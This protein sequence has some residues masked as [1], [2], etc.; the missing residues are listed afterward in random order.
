MMRGMLHH[1][2]LNVSNLEKST[3]FWGEL[4]E[5]LGYEPF[6][7][8]ESGRSFKLGDTYLVFVQ[9]EKKFL[10]SSYHRKEVGL[11]HLA[12]YADSREHVDEITNQLK[13]KDVSILYSDRHPHA[14]GPNHYAVFFEDP[15]RIKVEIVAP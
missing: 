6:Q 10:E 14:G 15:D 5:E 7:S 9:T 4:L 13:E 1:I 12:F 2:E 8:W 11:N 3:A